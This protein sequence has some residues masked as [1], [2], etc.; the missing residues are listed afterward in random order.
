MN[1]FGYI[2]R[3]LVLV[4]ILSGAEGCNKEKWF[5][6]PNY[7][8]E[9]F[10]SYAHVDSMFS[11]DDVRWSYNQNTVSG[12]YIAFD[13]NVVHSGNRSLKFFGYASTEDVVSKNSIVKQQMAFYEG[14]V[15][16]I[17]AW[18][19][20]EGTANLDWLFFFDFEEQAAIG[21]GPGMRLA[22]SER[23]IVVEHKFLN[24]DVYQDEGQEIFL[25]RN[26]WFNLTMEVKLSQKKQGYVRVWQDNVQII[27]ATNRKTL[28]KDFLYSQ[29]GTKG[30]YQ[31]IEFGI[32]A[33]TRN[34][35]V[36]LYMDD[37]RVEK[38]N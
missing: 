31:S 23:G 28:P 14:D 9:D 26:Q 38:I 5:D 32:T 36:T 7:M 1:K 16:R 25:P 33:N 19:Y 29:Q 13:T 12:N 35:N 34:S 4:V 22:N 21:A 30:M 37:I 8:S 2:I 18:Y 11:N 3:I 27:S 10:E 24:D 17:S 20:I 6:G 15:V